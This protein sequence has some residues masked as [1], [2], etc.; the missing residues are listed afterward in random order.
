MQALSGHTHGSV[1][2]RVPTL[3]GQASATCSCAGAPAWR[4]WCDSDGVC[5]WALGCEGLCRCRTGVQLGS[6]SPVSCGARRGD[7]SGAGVGLVGSMRP[8]DVAIHPTAHSVWSCLHAAGLQQLHVQVLEPQPF[9]GGEHS[10]C[11]QAHW[12][13]RLVTT[14]PCDVW[15]P[16]SDARVPAELRRTLMRTQVASSPSLHS[17]A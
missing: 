12:S 3:S 7:G 17:A 11:P 16:T 2:P 10:S 5:G 14:E 1:V 8:V 9:P 4:Q 15:A 13:S 6:W